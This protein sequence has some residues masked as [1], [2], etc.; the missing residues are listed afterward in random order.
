[1]DKTLPLAAQT[2]LGKLSTWL[3]ALF[4][5][6]AAVSVLL[7]L[8][9]DVLLFDDRWWDITSG[10]LTLATLAALITGLVARFK[11]KDRSPFVLISISIS[12]L[13][14]LFF[15]LHSLFIND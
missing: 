6:G 7:V 14:I 10:I 9:F 5:V 2:A 13:A 1:M 8:V 12:I 4:V 11:D 3:N 15:L